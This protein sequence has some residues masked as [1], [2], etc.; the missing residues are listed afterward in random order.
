MNSLN[1]NEE[2]LNHHHH[3]TLNSNSNIN[4]MN[5]NSTTLNGNNNSLDV[6]FNN[7]QANNSSNNNG[8]NFCIVRNNIL[9]NDIPTS[10][11]QSGSITAGNSTFT[12]LQPAATVFT[13]LPSIDTLSSGNNKRNIFLFNMVLNYN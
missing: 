9:P 6:N 3:H 4:G 11:N 12:E 2:T 8:S 13:Q 7:L 1:N 5:N 10:N